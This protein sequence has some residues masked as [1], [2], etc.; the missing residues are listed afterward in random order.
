MISIVLLGYVVYNYAD[1]VNLPTSC[2]G[3]ICFVNKENGVVAFHLARHPL[4]KAFQLSTEI[5]AIELAIL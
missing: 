5:M 4:R 3:Y 1:L 2:D